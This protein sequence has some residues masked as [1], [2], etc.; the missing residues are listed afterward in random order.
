MK[1]ALTIFVCLV[2]FSLAFTSNAYATEIHFTD[3]AK[4][5]GASGTYGRLTFDVS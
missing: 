3:Y 4:H 5:N 1:R 2:G